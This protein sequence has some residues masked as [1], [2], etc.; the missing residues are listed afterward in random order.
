MS[1]FFRERQNAEDFHGP[2][3]VSIRVFAL[4]ALGMTCS[5]PNGHCR[6][7]NAPKAGTREGSNIQRYLRQTAWLAALALPEK[8]G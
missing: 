2:P 8:H 3:V 6:A 7:R 4:P 1:R 5:R